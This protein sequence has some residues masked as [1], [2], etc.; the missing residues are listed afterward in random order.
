MNAVAEITQIEE[1]IKAVCCLESSAANFEVADDEGGRF[2][3][4]EADIPGSCSNEAVLELLS[5]IDCKIRSID[6][7]CSC[8]MTVRNS[9]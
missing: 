7:V 3:F 4:F 6:P 1:I 8:V 9:Q 5:E 2:I